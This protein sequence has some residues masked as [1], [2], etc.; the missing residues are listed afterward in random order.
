MSALSPASLYQQQL[1]LHQEHLRL[2]LQKRKTLGWSRMI[3]F[4]VT[5]IISYQVF[6]TA[7]IYGLIPLVMGMGLL[8]FLVARDVDNQQQIRNTRL[9]IRMNEEELQVL[10][11]QFTHR[12]DGAGFAPEVHDYAHDLD[13]FGKAS[14]YQ[15]MNRC[16][17]DG[18][19][20]L[21]AGS[22][23]Q[24][25]P[26]TAIKARQQAMA[27]LAPQ[28]AWRQQ[29]QAFAE[30][31]PVTTHTE[32]RTASWLS[33]KDRHFTG[34]H[35][36][37]IIVI[38]PVITLGSA[39]AAILGYIPGGSFSF[40]YGIYLALS[41]LLSRNT[42]G[43]YLQLSGIVK[44]IATLQRLVA[45][46]EN[47]S[48]EA[49]L[50]RQLQT[51]ARQGHEPASVEIQRLKAILDRFDLRL[52][53][54]G[55]L[56]FNSFLLWDVRQMMALN[57]W[58]KKNRNAV[59]HWFHLIAE[60]ELLHS[61]ATIRLNHPAWALPQFT[62]PH[63]HFFATQ[64]GHPLLPDHARVCSDFHLEGIAKIGL[65]TGSN[66]AGKSTFLRSL[67]VNTVLAQ[68]GA[69]VCASALQLS[70]VHLMSSMRIADNLAENTSTF[71][72][73]L[74]K[75]KTIIEAVNRNEKIF[76]LL[77]E[78]LRGTNSLDR[79][80][81]SA[82]LIRQLIAQKAVAVIATHDVELAKLEETYPGSIQN[83]HFDVQ[84]SGEEL[85]FDYL[86]KHG[87]CTSLNASILM[88]KIGI[89]L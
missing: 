13:L 45:W 80:T 72:A 86:L 8:L 57:A 20:K 75:L 42:V 14:L 28:L 47:K 17:S 49:P 59:P 67:G 39:A 41:I 31:D 83:Y 33:A 36:K 5:L 23:L 35:W 82:A 60:T 89:R 44:E 32:E 16:F 1:S 24:A 63:F 22:L 64:L 19:K 12:P 46:I 74:K 71:Y 70:H 62:E 11:H 34:A 69:P 18:G 87:V 66:M 38:Y 29:L 78:I 10:L 4:L 21:L 85:Y 55:L 50:L 52:N 56:F 2:L 25:Q 43:P 3:V 37:W 76:I 7:G 30:Q 26:L 84:V 15:W 6:V 61:L 81:G 77:D 73:E 53:I 79:H 54:A 68:M 40:L 88:K 48:F 58:R 9:L 51:A 65:I 27:E